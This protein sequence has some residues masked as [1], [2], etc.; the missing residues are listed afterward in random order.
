M[1]LFFSTRDTYDPD[2]CRSSQ[3]LAAGTYDS[4]IKYIKQAHKSF[5]DTLTIY[6]NLSNKQ[7]HHRRLLWFYQLHLSINY[8][9]LSSSVWHF[10][11]WEHLSFWTTYIMIKKIPA[12][13]LQGC[14]YYWTIQPGIQNSLPWIVYYIILLYHNIECCVSTPL[15]CLNVS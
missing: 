12:L 3:T 8:I 14:I 1:D 13:W 9:T 15:T 5:F 7:W 10:I 6:G 11:L 2:P 4:R